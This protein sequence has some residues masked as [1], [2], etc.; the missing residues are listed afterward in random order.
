ME[1]FNYLIDQEVAE[2]NSLSYDDVMQD[3]ILYQV[4]TILKKSVLVDI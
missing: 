3:E 1:D 4:N 2:L